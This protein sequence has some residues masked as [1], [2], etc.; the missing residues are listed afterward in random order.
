MVWPPTLSMPRRAGAHLVPVP[1]V[2]IRGLDG[3]PHDGLLHG[4]FDTP[5]GRPAERS[6]IKDMAASAEA[7][8]SCL[9]REA[10]PGAIGG[11]SAYP[12]RLS[13]PTR[14][15]TDEVGDSSSRSRRKRG[16]TSPMPGEL[17]V[18]S[19]MG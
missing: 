14:G 18:P 5:G 10:R 15:D 8:E 7:R 4:Y 9:Q 6:K 16:C 17:C 1:V 19:S 11:S 3:R 2:L 13:S 12:L